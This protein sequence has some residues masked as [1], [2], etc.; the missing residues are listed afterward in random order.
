M[1]LPK[2]EHVAQLQAT[3]SRL[4]QE[5]FDLDKIE[6]Y[7]RLSDKES[8]YQVISDKTFQDLDMNEVFMFVDRTSSKVG[9]QFLY[10]T[11]RTIPDDRLQS[12]RFEKLINRIERT[13][14][15]KDTIL[16]ELSTLN[17]PNAYSV[18]SLFLRDQVQK[19]KW[20]WVI[21]ALS[22]TSLCVVLL[23]IGFPQALLLLLPLLAVNFLIHY[24][25][26]NNLY[27]YVGSIPQLARMN[28]AAKEI[29]NYE[30]NDELSPGIRLSIDAID[31]LGAQMSLFKLEAKLQSEIGLI[32]DYALEL[33]KALFLL[34]PLVFFNVLEKINVKRTE[35]EAVY[36]YVGEIDVAMSIRFLREQLPFFCLP[37]LT[38]DK[39]QLTALDAYHPLIDQSVPNSISLVDHSALL[40]GS[41]MSGKTTFIRTIGINAL[42]AQT[43]NTCFA[44]QWRMPRLKIHSAIRISDD[45]LSAKSYYFDEVLTIKTLLDQSQT[46]EGHLFLLDELFKGTNT[47]ERIASGKAVL[48]YLNQ[49]ANLVF[50]STH[51]LELAELVKDSFQLFH[52]TE[53]VEEGTVLFDYTLKK[54]NL[55]HTNAIRILELNQYPT[56]VTD[57]ATQ[58]ARH[59]YA[60]KLKP[61][62]G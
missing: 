33:V 6:R 34:E 15:L 11:V 24:W 43:L 44:K 35:I 13:P 21:K 53:I 4:K 8:V 48:S 32:V 10:H 12:E 3:A 30:V 52:F 36:R 19:P 23:S 59:L 56:E 25:N 57:E 54:G 16:L 60:N 38:A 46:A 29:S 20:F 51:D 26:K 14:G 58:L 55:T 40:T 31:R 39:K 50:V 2:A 5:F 27:Q 17:S 61:D 41:N 62:A 22:F 1:R 42:M 47:V 7:F 18:V 45:L 37:T 49:K 9:Q 28:Q